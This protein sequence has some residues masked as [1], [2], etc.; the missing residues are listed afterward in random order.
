[1]ILN[2]LLVLACFVHLPIPSD[3]VSLLVVLFQ[4]VCEEI[5]RNIK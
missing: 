1:M 5:K 2:G 3:A 4:M